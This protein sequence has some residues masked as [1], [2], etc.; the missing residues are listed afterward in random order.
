MQ[1]VKNFLRGKLCFGTIGIIA[2]VNKTTTADAIV[3]E[4]VVA[5]LIPATAVATCLTDAE[6]SIMTTFK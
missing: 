4:D 6:T 3:V 2:V 1:Y 5:H